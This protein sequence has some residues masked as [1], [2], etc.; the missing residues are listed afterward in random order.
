VQPSRNAAYP[1]L[2]ESVAILDSG[3]SRRIAP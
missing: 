2:P 1:G 3:V